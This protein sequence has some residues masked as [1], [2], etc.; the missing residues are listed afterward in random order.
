MGIFSFLL[1]LLDSE[2]ESNAIL[3]NFGN[4]SSYNTVSLEP[5]AALLSEPHITLP[6]NKILRKFKSVHS[7]MALQPLL[8]LG[9]PHKTPPFVPICS[10]TPPSSYPQQLSSI[11]LNHTCPSS[12][13]S[14]HWSHSIE[15]SVLRPF[16][17]YFPLADVFFFVW[18]RGWFFLD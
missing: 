5:Y 12:S 16:L 13:W 8:G 1:G 17:E 2:D 7:S 18:G 9:L 3:Q 14:S 10:F 6:L 15:V 11:S 4:H